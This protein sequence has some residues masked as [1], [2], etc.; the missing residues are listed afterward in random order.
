MGVESYAVGAD[1]EYPNDVSVGGAITAT[2]DKGVDGF[3]VGFQVGDTS[4]PEGVESTVT[5]QW[6]LLDGSM[7]DIDLPRIS[8]KPKDE[9]TR[10]SIG[11]TAV[12]E[13]V[14]EDAGVTAQPHVSLSAGTN[15][16]GD[17][18]L[19]LRGGVTLP[20]AGA[21]FTG[22]ISN[23]DGGLSAGLSDY[24]VDISNPNEAFVEDDIQV[25]SSSPKDLSGLNEDALNESL[26]L[27]ESGR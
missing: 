1:V 27:L 14:G 20:D 5:Q 10:A 3:N 22:S 15:E 11:A 18:A 21:Q 6:R 12:F 19:L 4:A 8:A 25:S 13:P 9:D 7:R 2:P 17:D 23:R 24:A 16:R 26:G